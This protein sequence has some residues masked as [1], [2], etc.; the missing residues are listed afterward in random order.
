MAIALARRRGAAV[1]AVQAVLRLARVRVDLRPRTLCSGD[2]RTHPGQAPAPL[3][4]A[5]AGQAGGAG[6]A[7]LARRRGT[8]VAAVQAGLRLARVRVDLAPR[9]LC[10]GDDHHYL[11]YL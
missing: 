6:A 11:S 7:P 10:S 5:R 1:A 4:A 2:D 3:G 8:A 9:T